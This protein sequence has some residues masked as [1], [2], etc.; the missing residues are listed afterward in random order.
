VLVAAGGEAG[1]PNSG[2]AGKPNTG[3]LK[4][5]AELPAELPPR[6]SSL[7]YDG[8]EIWVAIYHGRGQYATL[9]PVTLRWRISNIEEHHKAIREVVGAFE[10]P[11]AMCFVKDKLWVADSYG[12]SFGS[13]DT[14][15]WK[16]ARLFRGKYR[17]ADSASQSY[18]DMAYDG[19]HLWIAWHWFKYKLPASR[20][21]LLLKIDPET[22][23]VVGKYPLPAGTRNDGAHGLAWD[24]T[25][26]WHMKD[27][28]L[29]SIDPSTGMVI[30]QY[31]LDQIRR[32]NGLAWDGEALWIAEFDGKV[33]RLPF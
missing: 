17:P 30:S 20:T 22:G 7:A 23:K 1:K 31:L 33:W 9:D 29:S 4:L 8:K 19:S 16:V 11:G 24:G 2:E 12:E 3:E 21:Q 14:Q 10:S 15:D 27:S 6:I 28:K 25:R 32:P 18:S 5:V 13:I 26:L